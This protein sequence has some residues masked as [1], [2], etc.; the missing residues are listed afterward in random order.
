M[1]AQGAKRGR[2]AARCRHTSK[3]PKCSSSIRIR[4]V[5]SRAA[6]TLYTRTRF[7]EQGGSASLF[8]TTV[9]EAEYGY[10]ERAHSS[11]VGSAGISDSHGARCAGFHHTTPDP[12]IRSRTLITR[13]LTYLTDAWDGFVHASPRSDARTRVSQR[14]PYGD[15]DVRVKGFRTVDGKLW[16]EIEVISHSLC[17]SN[18][19]PTVKAGGWITAHDES[20]APTVWFS[21]RG[22]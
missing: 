20:G 3:S 18:K 22:C 8:A 12:S 9:D 1:F 21:S 2:P 6:L 11:T 14:R 15:E 10:E 5:C 17:E 4:R 13:S 7:G 16:V 19:P